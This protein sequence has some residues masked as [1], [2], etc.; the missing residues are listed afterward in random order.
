MNLLESIQRVADDCKIRSSVSDISDRIIR[1]INRVSGEIWDGFRWSFR[2]RSYRMKTEIDYTTGTV[3]ATNSSRTLTG[4]GTTFTSSHVGWHIYFPGDSIQNVYRVLAYVSATELTLDI[5]YLGTT[6]SAKTYVLRKFDY[7]LP[8]EI[9]DLGDLTATYDG[10]DIEVLDPSSNV[11]ISSSAIVSGGPVA[12]SIHSSDFTPTTYSTGTVSGTID[13]NTLTGSSTAWLDNVY[14]GDT[15]TIGSYDYT[16]ES[17]LS[18]TSIRL[19][20]YL[21]STCSASSYVISRQFGRVLRISH[22]SNDYHTIEIRGLR[23]YA[24]LV[25]SNDTNELL[26]RYAHPVILKVSALELKS[27]D[28]KKRRELEQES[29]LALARARAE[30]EAGTVRETNAPIHSYR[31]GRL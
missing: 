20:N 17:I 14:P 18:D 19:Y 6:G 11:R 2:N 8:T 31:Q 10:R 27:Q 5:P 26:Y 30:D 25:N 22:P 29:E 1:E 24:P 9:W 4:S 13:T 28:D 7:V 23:K 12:A 3:T 15:I 16:I 21:Q